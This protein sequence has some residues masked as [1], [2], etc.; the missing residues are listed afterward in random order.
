MNTSIYNGL[1]YENTTI[2]AKQPFY[3][4]TTSD[5]SFVMELPKSEQDQTFIKDKVYHRPVPNFFV[6]S[7]DDQV[8]LFYYCQVHTIS[9][10]TPPPSTPS[11]QS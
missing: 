10:Y 7:I 11:N 1:F 9:F 3:L 4:D 8:A 2:K 5:A 6:L